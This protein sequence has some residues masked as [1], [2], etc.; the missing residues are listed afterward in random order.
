MNRKKIVLQAILSVAL[1]IG[2]GA[3]LVWTLNTLEATVE[4]LAVI[5]LVLA[6][7]PAFILGAVWMERLTGRISSYGRFRHGSARHGVVFALAIIA[8][9]ALLLAFN[10]GYLPVA[11]KAFFFSWPMLFFL[12]GAFK[13]CRLH[14]VQGIILAAVGIFFLINRLPP[15]YSKEAFSEQFSSTYWPVLIIIAGILFFLN[16]LFK[17]HTFFFHHRFDVHPHFGGDFCHSK[18][19]RAQKDNC[20]DGTVHGSYI[21]GSTEHIFL[22][23]VFRG[24]SIDT[25]FGGMKLDLRQTSLP[26]GETVLHINV[27]FGGVEIIVPVDWHV[28]VHPQAIFGG[29]DNKRY[30]QTVTD[31]SRKLVIDGQC[32]FGGI[33]LR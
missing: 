31:P 3:L 25:I 30:H 19:N 8:A 29:V 4:A 28:D 17:P 15:I 2:S 33:E 11:W 23:P 24:G 26:E 18:E 5:L 32:V 20:V 7:I 14:F 13:L 21:F 6:A 10:T 27:L 22:E 16:M 1:M 9:G 12:W